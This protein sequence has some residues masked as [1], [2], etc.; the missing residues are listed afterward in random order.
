[1]GVLGQEAESFTQLLAE[2]LAKTNGRTC[3]CVPANRCYC[4]HTCSHVVLL[5]FIFIRI[6]FC[7]V[8]IVCS[9]VV[10]VCQFL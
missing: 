9:L 8:Y 1:M 7:L 4:V 6:L 5:L 10:C 2:K 3:M